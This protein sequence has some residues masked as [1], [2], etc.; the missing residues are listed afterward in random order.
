MKKIKQLVLNIIRK[1]I[2]KYP[3]IH[4]LYLFYIKLRGSFKKLSPKQEKFYYQGKQI[5]FKALDYVNFSKKKRSYIEF[6]NSLPEDI[7]L[8]IMFSGTIFIQE[9]R[10]NRPIRLSKIFLDKGFPVLFSYF[11]WNQN[12]LIPDNHTNLLF[13][14]PIDY[15]IRSLDYLINYN[16]QNRTKVFIVSFPYPEICK[17]INRL[18]VNN[19]VTLYDARDDWEEFHKVGMAKWYD[20]SAEKYIT[21]NCDATLAISAPLQKKLQSY[22]NTGNIILC[23]N[24]Y[25]TTF[26][27]TKLNKSG[28]TT[29][30]RI[31][32]YF[33]HLTEKWF[34]WEA[35]LEIAS[36]MPDWKFEIIGHGEPKNLE[37]PAN[38]KLFGKRN[39]MEINKIASR[40][41]VAMIVFKINKLSEAVDPIKIYEYLALELPTVS[42][43]MPQ[44]NDY[45]YAYTA[46]SVPEFISKLHQAAEMDIDPEI[47]WRFLDQNRWEDRA[48]QFLDEIKKVKKN[49]LTLSQLLIN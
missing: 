37:L 24:A 10:A 20:K 5:K 4:A 28:R 46:G 27:K 42:F 2:N 14:S 15:T 3:F 44:I 31:A 36:K 48:D 26:I 38:I 6:V 47:I 11:R 16:F 9:E 39:H 13:Q 30:P 7:P 18:N 1:A 21:I 41:N 34:N 19:W 45:P 25:D 33:G 12:D 40:W 22:T 35:L 29:G 17:Y 32:G 49:A 8:I 23:P 43:T